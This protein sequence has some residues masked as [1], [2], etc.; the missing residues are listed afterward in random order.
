M[1]DKSG[2]ILNFDAGV[3][4]KPAVGANTDEAGT[5]PPPVTIPFPAYNQL[6]MNQSCMRPF[7]QKLS[8]ERSCWESSFPNFVTNQLSVCTAGAIFALAWKEDWCGPEPQGQLHSMHNEILIY[9][10]LPVRIA[11]T[12]TW[13]RTRKPW[14]QWLSIGSM[15]DFQLWT[16]CMFRL[17]AGID[18][19][20]NKLKTLN[21]ELI[22]IQA[23]SM[24]EAPDKP[25]RAKVMLFV[26][27]MHD[28][29]GMSHMHA[30]GRR[31]TSWCRSTLRSR[32]TTRWWTIG[33]LEPGLD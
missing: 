32:K 27:H 17:S 3:G 5:A 20:L 12:H 14:S 19:P 7:R 33:H 9:F 15:L 26:C 23:A 25:G 29:F 18:A 24:A 28:T 13:K 22:D 6:A 11:W 1:Q 30:T 16:Y 31:K 2:S 10:W 8:K 4:A 21:A